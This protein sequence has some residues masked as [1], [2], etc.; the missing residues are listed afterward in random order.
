M[1]QQLFSI[2]IGATDW[3][4]VLPPSSPPWSNFWNHIVVV[5]GGETYQRASAYM[6]VRMWVCIVLVSP[7]HGNCH[8]YFAFLTLDNAVDQQ[9]PRHLG[10]HEPLAGVPQVVCFTNRM[11]VLCHS[12]QWMILCGGKSSSAQ[13][14][15]SWKRPHL[16]LT[17]FSLF[18]VVCNVS[19]PGN[20]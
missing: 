13:I 20:D 17:C 18:E 3:L 6:L 8:K 14:L 10:C 19:E 1:Q 9:F 2:V 11:T 7:G 5:Q 4:L 16:S 15:P 12:K